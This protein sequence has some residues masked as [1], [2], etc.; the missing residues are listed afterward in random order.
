MA[1][2][3]ELY[4]FYVYRLKTTI[5]DYIF[6]SYQAFKDLIGYQHQ[7]KATSYDLILQGELQDNETPSELYNRIHK[8]KLDGKLIHLRASDVFV[9]VRDGEILVYYLDPIGFT[10]IHC[11]F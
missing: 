6:I 3:Q 8:K 5:P 2:C 9:F 11:F 7:I 4:H 1:N 10:Q